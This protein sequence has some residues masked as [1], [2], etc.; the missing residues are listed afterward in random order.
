ML[1]NLDGDVLG[2]ARTRTEPIYPSPGR[3]EQDA[4]QIWDKLH[5]LIREVLSSAGIQ[6]A[7][8]ASVG[9]TSQ[10]T[11]IVIWDE[12][13]G[14]AVIP[15]IV[16]SDLRGVERANELMQAGFLAAAQLASA[17]LEAAF[18]DA[19]EATGL[20]VF[21]SDTSGL[22]WGNIDS[23]VISR[24]TGGSAHISDATQ[25]WATG[26]LDLESF[27]LNEPLIQFQNLSPSL[28]PRQ[29]DTW[30]Q[31]G[32]TSRDVFGA[33]VGIGA[34]IADQQGAMFPHN[35]LTPGNCKITYGTSGTLD[36][37]TGT[38]FKLISETIF[39]FIQFKTGQSPAFCLEGMVNTAGTTLD[40]LVDDLQ[41]VD[42]IEQVSAVAEQVSD[43]E[44][45]WVLPSL[46]GVGAPH[47]DNE[48]RMEIG[49]LSRGST[50]A[51]V[52]RATL[53][54]IGFRIRE[55]FDHIYQLSELPQP[56]SIGV[57][58][59]AAASDALLQIQADILGIPVCRLEVG[60]AT[61]LGAAICAGIGAGLIQLDDLS[62]FARYSRV[63]DP[64]IS[65]VASKGVF[66]QWRSRVYHQ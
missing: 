16:W 25:L 65:T 64:G 41:L 37:S 47:G 30:G 51:H 38:D 15:M 54:G 12:R 63:F 28:F 20:T 11:S 46:L 5:G 45:V 55:I 1:V 66:E 61:A 14:E 39:P 3:V 59:G 32:V 33:E 34:V 35:C 44:G 62:R 6:P 2:I 31:L 23:F 13:T 60:E 27:E 52:V 22:R 10:R 42:S 56:D 58:G 19:E 17:K 49:G 48:R 8:I 50:R 9:V 53:E 18:R 57:D 4:N 40:W 29:V 24:L 43:T 7:D 21:G 36:V 26:Y